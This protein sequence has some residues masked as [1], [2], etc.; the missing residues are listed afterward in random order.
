MTIRQRARASTIDCVEYRDIVQHFHLNKLNRG[1][2]G[3]GRVEAQ[4]LTPLSAIEPLDRSGD[5]PIKFPC[6]PLQRICLWDG[7]WDRFRIDPRKVQKS[8][9][10]SA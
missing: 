9:K 4:K 2:V 7:M 5:C 1:N 10:F 8:G 6:M 3:F